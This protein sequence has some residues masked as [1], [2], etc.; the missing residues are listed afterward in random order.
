M[1]GLWWYT[2]SGEVWGLFK[3]IEEAVPSGRYLHYDTMKYHLIEWETILKAF[4]NTQDEIDYYLSKGYKSLERGSVIY[5]SFN[6]NYLVICS[7]SLIKDDTFKKKVIEY[8][9][10]DPDNVVFE[11]LDHYCKV[12]YTGN[13][14]LDRIIDEF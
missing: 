11:A 14:N 8:Y 7:K 12:S 3:P 2:D 9:E 13:P 4:C 10:L 6:L 5:D 1:V